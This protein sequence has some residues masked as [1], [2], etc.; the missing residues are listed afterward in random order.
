MSN[1]SFAVSVTKSK[2]FWVARS[3]TILATGQTRE[4]AIG[5]V[6]NLLEKQQ[7]PPNDNG[8]RGKRV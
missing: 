2:G 8:L 3:G 1:H 4:D 5:R 7:T 6:M